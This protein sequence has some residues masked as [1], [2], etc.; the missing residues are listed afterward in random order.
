MFL[1]KIYTPYCTTTTVT[2]WLSTSRPSQLSNIV[3]RGVED[4]EK[5]ATKIYKVE[6]VRLLRFNTLS[7]L[8]SRKV[9]AQ[10][11]PSQ[12]R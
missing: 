3:V 11:R 10:R 9:R 5:I 4:E 12:Q 8:S 2:S 7:H 1:T 6:K